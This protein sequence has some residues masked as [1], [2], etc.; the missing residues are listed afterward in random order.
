MDNSARVRGSKNVGKPG[1]QV[2]YFD[3]WQ[4]E[5][6]REPVREALSALELHRDP[7]PAIAQEPALEHP[8]DARAME[9]VEDRRLLDHPRVHPGAVAQLAM[10]HL[11]RD[12]TRQQRVF[13][14]EHLA[15][16]AR[17]DPLHDPVRAHDRTRAKCEVVRRHDGARCTKLATTGHRRHDATDMAVGLGAW[18]D[19]TADDR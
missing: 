9:T 12:A 18:L 19:A 5:L 11:E 13:R 8:H 17:P 10:Q 16:A 14:F 15:H 6:A 1:H 3:G 7:R 4:L 2:A